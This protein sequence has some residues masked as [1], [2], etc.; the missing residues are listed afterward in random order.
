ME[1]SNLAAAESAHDTLVFMGG[2]PTRTIQ[3][4]PGCWDPSEENEEDL[5]LIRH[6]SME[7]A[8]FRVRQDLRT[9]LRMQKHVDTY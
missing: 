7:G 2:R 6:Y 3:R 8:R 1:A 9:F 4:D 5:W